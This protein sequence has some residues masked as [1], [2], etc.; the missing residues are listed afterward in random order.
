M[1]KIGLELSEE[2]LTLMKEAG[3]SKK[4]I[5]LYVSQT[6]VGKF[7]SSRCCFYLSWSLWRS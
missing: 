2:E 1:D 3:Y 4:A 7:V 5:N 6:N